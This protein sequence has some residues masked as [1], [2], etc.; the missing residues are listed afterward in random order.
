MYKVQYGQKLK[1]VHPDGTVQVFAQ[2]ES[3]K[4]DGHDLTQKTNRRLADGNN[5]RYAVA[6][7][8]ASHF[9]PVDIPILYMTGDYDFLFQDTEVENLRKFLLD[10]GTII[11][12]AARGRK[13]FSLAVAREMRRVLPSKTF[14]RTPPDHP[15]YNTR[16]R[17]RKVLTLANG[18]HFT[19]PPEIYAIDIGTRAAAILV[20]GG[21]GAAWSNAKYHAGGNHI[22]GES[23]IRLGVNLVAYVLGSTEYSRFLAQEFPVYRQSTRPGDVMRFAAVRYSGSWNVNPALQNSLMEG[24][25]D[26]TGIG[27]DFSPH[28]VDLSDPAI[29]HHPMLFMTGHY[30]FHWSEREVENLRGYLLR[31]GMVFA[32]A[33]AGFKSFDLA[34]R[35]EL[36]KVF[37]EHDLIHLPPS[38]P[39]FTS[40]WNPIGSVTYNSA[41]LRDNPNLEFPHIEAMFLD[42]RPCVFYTPFDLFGGLNR[43]SNAY[44]RGFVPDD[45]L[46]IA[47]NVITHALAQ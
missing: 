24:L 10:G 9:D 17:I 43:E 3:F 44:A 25:F 42:G 11:F 13:A 47:I 15:I 36:S 41:A 19:K 34:F 8:S 1:Y 6:P 22:V 16:Y 4:S 26:N 5:Y 27:V 2:W 30:D 39:L 38:H 46:R 33:A 37:P 45:A 12:N 40:G 31:G 32:S 29:G 14:L 7:L 21:M 28:A 23:A 20:P 35:R 18:V